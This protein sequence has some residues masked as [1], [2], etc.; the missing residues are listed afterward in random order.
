MLTKHTWKWIN[1][2][3]FIAMVAV[4]ALA[5]LLP[6][7]GMTTGQISALYPSPLTPAPL[8]FGIWGLIYLL[9]ILFVAL[10]FKS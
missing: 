1:L 8:S 7:G 4:N 5:E 3:A 6:I 2:T 9:L 10:P